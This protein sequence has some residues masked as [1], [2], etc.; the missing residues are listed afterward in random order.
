MPR[1]KPD[2]PLVTFDPEELREAITKCMAQAREFE[3]KKIRALTLADTYRKLLILHDEDAP[4]MIRAPVAAESQRF[5]GMTMAEAAHAVLAETPS[6]AMHGR[7]ILETLAKGGRPVNAAQAMSSLQNA[8]T[9]DP[10]FERVRG[11]P[12]FWRLAPAAKEEAKT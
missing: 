7:S 10:R 8:M 12:N 9:R 5:E 6:H 3:D 2:H 4:G 11:K 1:T